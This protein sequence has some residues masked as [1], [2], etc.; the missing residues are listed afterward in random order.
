MRANDGRLHLVRFVTS[1]GQVR[2]TASGQHYFRTR[3]TTYVAHVPVSIHGRRSNGQPY[4]RSDHLPVIAF[5]VGSIALNA[6]T[7][8]AQVGR[9]VRRR[10][11]SELRVREGDKKSSWKSAEKK[12]I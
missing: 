2:V 10:V 5:G 4:S 11:L 3:R 8:R 6:A 9:E 7:T 1:T 12:N